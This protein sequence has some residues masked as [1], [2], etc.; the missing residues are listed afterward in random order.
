MLLSP[1]RRARGDA[2]LQAVGDVRSVVRDDSHWRTK[3]S[4]GTS[5]IKLDHGGADHSS[6]AITHSLL[7]SGFMRDHILH[8]RV[9]TSTSIP[10]SALDLITTVAT[11]VMSKANTLSR[12]LRVATINAVMI[13]PSL[14]L[15]PHEKGACNSQVRAEV[16]YGERETWN[17]WRHMPE[18][19]DQ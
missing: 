6:N 7:Q 10:L 19:P 4:M 13:F 1:L 17:P 8:G 5:D 12:V 15:F 9:I 3:C 18:P 16:N 11:D 2:K 14:A